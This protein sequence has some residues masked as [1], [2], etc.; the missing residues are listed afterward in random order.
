MASPPREQILRA[1]IVEQRGP[2]NQLVVREAAIEAERVG[3]QGNPG[4]LPMLIDP[5]VGLRVIIGRKPMSIKPM[6]IKTF[7][8]KE[9]TQGGKKNKKSR[10]TKRS[11]R[12]SSKRVK[13]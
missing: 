4:P 6:S 9:R 13:K 11:K 2:P 5:P 3:G 12:K 1:E 7:P 10:K 8:T